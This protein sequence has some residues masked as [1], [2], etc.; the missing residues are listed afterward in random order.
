MRG[1]S[2]GRGGGPR[3]PLL[4]VV[5][6]GYGL[7]PPSAGNAVSLARTPNLDGLFAR[8]PWAPLSVSGLAVGLPEG[9]M[10][11]SEVGHLNIGAGRV[12]YQELT[13]IN[14]AIEDGT[15]AANPV[16]D[17]AIDGAVRAGGAV[18]FMGLLSDGGVHSHN[19]HLYALVEG[20]RA[21]GA[22]RLYVHAFLD[23][24]DV[25]PTSGAGYVRELEGFLRELGAGRVATVMGRY[26]AMDRD[27]RWDRVER[28]WRAMVLGEGLETE[29]AAG[30]VERSYAEGTT[31]EFV[32]PTVVL[33]DEGTAAT[34]SD[35]DALVFF[36][37]RPDRARE[38]TRAFVDPAFAEFERPA[39][40]RVRFVCLTEYDPTI[41]APVA[42][43]KELP[44][45]VL[46]DVLAEA[47]LRQF[48]IAETE[49]Y[50][51]VTF[52]LNGGVEPPKPGEER[53]L[54][55]SP[56]VPTYDLQPEMSEPE[57]TRRLVEAIGAGA[58]DVY[59]VNYANCDMVGHT[60]VLEAAVKAVEAV[61]DGVGRIVK[62][63]GRAGG[64]ALV[65][66]DHGNAERMREP[67]GG[68]LTAHTTDEVPFLVV[69]DRVREVRAGGI[70]ADV[71]PSAL[72]LL[73]IEPPEEWT[74]RSLLVY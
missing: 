15:L 56:K 5:M 49:K 18:H 58:A 16:L 66:A 59:I 6:D 53:V 27:R 7:A 62:A 40:P 63:I 55:P 12:V 4:L 1:C 51:H 3:S 64:E 50:A 23:G 72:D 44:R 13:R 41:P 19:S 25:P 45:C 73:D 42:F 46:A 32:E 74:G 29:H 39:F 67:D 36:N 24:R 30:A 17:E 28:A 52:F 54:V 31:D 26:Y 34:V 65:T 71:A 9:Q 57:V 10:G 21:R 38:I 43:P 60:G 22:D 48:H 69:S 70:P 11:N 47:G 2:P 61:D 8:Y 37:F 33:G 35:G 68:P 20:A 14:A